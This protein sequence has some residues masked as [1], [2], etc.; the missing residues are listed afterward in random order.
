MELQVA[1]KHP[2]LNT[3]SIKSDNM[4]N[5]RQAIKRK[6]KPVRYLRMLNIGIL[7]WG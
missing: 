4:F 7:F 6:Y 1:A 2:T 5:V 3:G